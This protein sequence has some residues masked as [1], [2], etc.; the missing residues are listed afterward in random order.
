M[1]VHP[2]THRIAQL[3]TVHA[4]SGPFQHLSTSLVFRTDFTDGSHL[5][6]TDKAVA[7]LF[8]VQARDGS[9]PC[10]WVR[11]VHHLYQIHEASVARYA[12]NGVPVNPGLQDPADYLR[13]FARKQHERFVETGY[14][15]LDEASGTYRYTWKGAFLSAWKLTWPI[16]SIRVWLRHRRALRC[17]RAMGREDLGPGYRA[18]GADPAHSSA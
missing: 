4:G 3:M 1:L 16:K 13:T 2:E 12:A 17:L 11:E 18:L 14:L 6:T 15:A 5:G 8:P 9:M 7:S 10:P